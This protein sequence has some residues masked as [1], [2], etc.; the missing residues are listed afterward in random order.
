[1]DLR[2]ATAYITG[3]GSGIGFAIA[4]ALALEGTNLILASRRIDLLRGKAEELHRSH[5]VQTYA[6]EMD[7][8]NAHTIR[9]AVNDTAKN[10]L[11]VDVL[12]NNSG[13]GHD[14]AAVHLTEEDWDRVLD[15]NLKGAF[16]L[17]QELLPKMI[18]RRKGH[19]IN[20]SSQ[21]GLH[22]YANATAYCASK[23]GLIGFGQALQEEVRQYNIKVTNLMPALVQVPPPANPGEVRSGVLQVVDLA[24]LVGFALKQ[25]DRVK[26]ADLGLYHL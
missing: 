7:L 18:E 12:I 24:A 3:G 1:M 2:G 25:P 22:G 16:I 21:A 15:T 17:T 8:R 14:A 19:I 10:F 13:V 26:F 6:V 11:P 5:G 4:S 9:A 20:I 23:F